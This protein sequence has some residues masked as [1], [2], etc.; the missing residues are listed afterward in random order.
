MYDR[1]TQLSALELMQQGAESAL[2]LH[3][4]GYFTSYYPGLG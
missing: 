4:D 3:T 1:S 2:G